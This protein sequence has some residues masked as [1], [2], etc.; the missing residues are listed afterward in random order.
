[1]NEKIIKAVGIVVGIAWFT[2][3]ITFGW[4]LFETLAGR[5]GDAFGALSFF[6]LFGLLA[7]LFLGRALLERLL[8]ATFGIDGAVVD[9]SISVAS[10]SRR[11]TDVWAVPIGAATV[12]TIVGIGSI[13]QFPI[14]I[15]NIVTQSETSASIG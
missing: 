7:V 13:S 3:V 1:M 12:I 8:I 2:T 11:Y 6:Y 4:Q 5:F 9:T 15:G 14:D 10:T